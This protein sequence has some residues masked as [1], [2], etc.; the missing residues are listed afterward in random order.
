MSGFN[1]GD[2]VRI[3]PKSS[4]YG[5]VRQLPPDVIGI[6]DKL[7]CS[8]YHKTTDYKVIWGKYKYDFNYYGET[9]LILVG[10]GVFT[11]DLSEWL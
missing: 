6:I 5:G 2:K 7:I 8:P 1:I 11:E 9:D 4:F 3:S 10:G